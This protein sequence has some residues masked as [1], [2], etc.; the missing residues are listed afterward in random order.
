MT[1]ADTAAPRI[2]TRAGTHRYELRAAIE[3]PPADW[4]LALSAV[5]EETNGRKSWWALAHPPGKADFHHP[6]SFV[7]EL[8][9][10][11]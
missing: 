9:A 4:R 10:N 6:D 8:P 1:E 2:E 3:L 7:L 11:P 5:I